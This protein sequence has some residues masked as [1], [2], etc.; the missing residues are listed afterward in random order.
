M[1]SIVA[2]AN[3]II[4][5]DNIHTLTNLNMLSPDGQCYSFDHRG[6][7][8]SR[9]EGVGVLVLKRVSDAIRDN[10]TIRGIIRSTGCNQDGHTPSITLPSSEMQTRLIRDTY[11]KAGLSMEPTR[12]FEAHGTGTSVGDP[13]E[14]KALGA[15]FRHVRTTQDPL[16]VGAIKSN[17]GHMEGSSGVGGVIKAM[18]VL[19]KGL[20]PPNANFEK[21]N[22]KI[23]TD[24]LR[25][26]F[27]MEIMPWPTP[28]L[29]RASV[30]SFGNAGTNSHT[31]L[32]DVYHYLEARGL[33]ARHLTV[34]D[35]PAQVDENPNC[36]TVLPSATMAAPE[37]PTR[38]KLLLLSANDEKGVP[39]QAQA[40]VDHFRKH[41]DP[42]SPR[43]L[44]HLAYTLCFRRSALP[45]TSFAVVDSLDDLQKLDQLISPAIKSIANPSLGFVFAGQGAQWAGMGRELVSFPAFQESLQRSE[46]ILRRLGCPWSLHEAIWQPNEKSRLDD[47][48]RAQPC[49]T[50]LQIALVDLLRSLNVSPAVV[51]GHSSG[52]IAAAYCCGALS[53]DSALKVAY[54]RGEVCRVLTGP[55]AP[56][57]RGAMMSVGLSAQ[58]IGPYLAEAS[59]GFAAPGLTVACINSPRNVTVSGDVEQL[60]ALQTIL[61]ARQIFARKLAV[62]VA[63]HSPHMRRVADLYRHAIRKLLPGAQRL[64]AIAMISSVTGTRIS[65]DELLDPAYWERN[66]TSPVRF[67]DAIDTLVA[68]AAHRVRRKLDLSHRNHFR[69]DMIVE[70]SPH[71]ALQRPVRDILQAS[72]AAAHIRYAAL[73]TKGTDGVASTLA[74]LGAVK[75]LGA[76][77]DL[78]Q[79]NTLHADLDSYMALPDLPSY[80]FDHSQRYWDE[81]RLCA[82]YRLGGH[83]K[84]D[85]LGKPVVDWNP[86][87]PR[88][89]HF[90][91][92]SE[93]PWIEDH[94]VNGVLIYPGAGMLVMALEAAHQLTAGD[95]TVTALELSDVAF[96]K[97]ILISREAEGV[98]LQL[99]LRLAR[100]SQSVLS[101]R[102]EFRL[103]AN[104]HGE[105]TECCHGFVQTR[106]CAVATDRARNRGGSTAELA[107][108]RS[109]AAE[110]DRTCASELDIKQ[111]YT[112]I[113]RSGVE[114]GPAFQRVR[115]AFTDR[116]THRVRGT[117][118]P[119]AWPESEFPQPHL[120][121]PTSLDGVL[122][123][124]FACFGDTQEDAGL[125]TRIPT[126]LRRL[127][128][129]RAGV[130]APEMKEVEEYV[131]R[132]MEDRRG[133]EY[134]AFVLD[135]TKETVLVQFE[136][137]R[138]T[139][140]AASEGKAAEQGQGLHTAFHVEYRPEVELLGAGEMRR[141]CAAGGDGQLQR[142]LDMLAHKNGGLRFVE[143]DPGDAGLTRLVLECL[144]VRDHLGAV[145]W[146]RY[147]SYH[148]CAPSEDVLARRKE[149]LAAFAQ[150]T[151]AV[152]D[153]AK[154]PVKQGL[155]AG[156][157]DVVVA[158]TSWDV[159]HLRSLLSPDGRLILVESEDSEGSETLFEQQDGFYPGFTLQ[160]DERRVHVHQL[161]SSITQGASGRDI[162]IVREGNSSRQT[163]LTTALKE[164]WKQQ[165]IPN[166]TEG[167]LQEATQIPVSADT[168][169]VIL[170]ELDDPITRTLTPDR[171]SPF[172]TLCATASHIIWPTFAGGSA[173][174]KPAFA[175]VH[176]LTRVLRS[177]YPALTITVIDF[178]ADETLIPSQLEKLTRLLFARH[179]NSDPRII[180]SE[181]R[182]QDGILHIPRVTPATHTTHQ[183]AQRSSP[184]TTRLR[185]LSASPPLSL[186]ISSI[187]ILDTLAFIEDTASP[188]TPLA[189]DEIEIAT[190]AIGL[191][192]VD[193]LTALGH[194]PDGP[195]GQ[196]CAGIVTRTGPAVTQVQVGDR[197]ALATEH[198]SFKT[199]F[200]RGRV[201]VRIPDG[202][203]FTTASAIPAQASTAWTAI[204]R[205]AHLQPE[206]SILIHCVAGG[207]GQIAVQLARLLGATV[208]ATVG[209]AE[210][211]QL[212]MDQYQLPESHIFSSRDT[213]FAA[214]IMRATNDRGVDV[215]L[216]CLTGEGL[217][218]S[219]KCVAAYGRFVELARTNILDNAALPM[220]AFRKNVTFSALD[221]VAWR[222]ERAGVACRDLERVMELVGEGLVQPAWP[223]QVRDIGEVN[224]VFREVQLGDAVGKFVFEVRKESKVQATCDTRPSFYFEPN[225][226]FVIAGGLGGIGRATARWLVERGARNLILLSRFGPRTEEG[227]L[228]VQE[229]QNQ[230]VRVE[231]PACDIT[232][233]TRMQEV[234]RG[235]AARMPPIQGAFQM[236]IIARDSLFDT[237]T[238][239]DWQ[240][241]V[242]CKT[243][244]T[245]NLHAVLPRGM[246]FFIILA[247][248]SGLAGIKGQANYNAG[249]TFEDA[250]ARWRV[251]QGEKTTALD[252]GAMVDDGILNEDPNLLS[253]VL[254]YGSLEGITRSEFYGILDYYCD[255][256][257]D[258]G[259]PHEAQVAIGLGVG[260]SGLLGSVDHAKNPLLQPLML[261][262]ERKATASVGAGGDVGA[263]AGAM[264]RQR[265]RERLGAATSMEQAAEV[266]MQATIYQLGKSLVAMQ[267][268]GAIDRDRPLQMY[269]VDSLLAIELRNWIVK[270]FS[271][272][273]AVFETQ[274]ASTLRTLSM[275]V[276]GRTGIK[277]EY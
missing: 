246:D 257:R 132:A 90:L 194:L 108:C 173:W 69:V 131:Y 15:A 229:L 157:F 254:A 27:P 158:S 265:N 197:V 225:A 12:F 110:M 153:P 233:K 74:A 124:G 226:T 264:S 129:D 22:P 228:L 220:Y 232:D 214:G 59:V 165:G 122:H 64:P 58:D 262:A 40:Y 6:N 243:T 252:L 11:A 183:L 115:T 277:H 251:A 266:V 5:P 273:V 210:K 198:G 114:L 149:E 95:D 35:P 32:D 271:A 84:L 204:H 137:L 65:P 80:V 21:V 162:F 147:S 207:T 77:L 260:G 235:L 105:W 106:H 178:D 88:W 249:N 250:F 109:L 135:P 50:A 188:T 248:A 216:N 209:S 36:Q 215:V 10:D 54:H 46:K 9:S 2:G 144:S 112:T 57:P 139:T 159:S 53:A 4:S 142:Y 38:P 79:T 100:D 37:A 70:V 161:A 230:G 130:S 39:R 221:A 45:W 87:E 201:A 275:L 86:L 212:L 160:A 29:R 168:V 174:T 258:L 20:I 56:G 170:L 19:E 49:C 136:D 8:Y 206:E 62:P 179:I 52:E 119:Y 193:T 42:L 195:L 28:G 190:R 177:E 81:S 96:P 127:V 217:L 169:F 98:E 227:R 121:H 44:D 276:A 263:G 274:G 60:G 176:G 23:D 267:D 205:L 208:Y 202:I 3:V 83:P 236:S 133:A 61:D 192:L 128:V 141:Y 47:P 89:R 272:D 111:F 18:L 140:V 41:K 239:P 1:Q 247:S 17:I 99:G 180:D 200:A 14:A 253:K 125:K 175:D 101:Q 199:P 82:N 231:T 259:A 255:P 171:F 48:E 166:V 34:R 67:A 134:S 26:R 85:L 97:P 75:C 68:A 191:N 234:F 7:G 224:E 78:A 256:A 181:Y 151:W 150:L 126:H 218:A 148:L 104:H 102:A 156:G 237:L 213:A 113:T 116:A 92:A 219:W 51:V 167:D 138:L 240:V 91:R 146:P 33:R 203:S 31:V 103:F 155:E 186:H 16:W 13:G 63:Y 182:E 241:A 163:H 117:L 244:G 94:S 185:A 66:M 93:L 223:L 245:W 120:I 172:Q 118:A 71:A 196:E 30:N 25:I 72:R 154:S 222:A 242:D 55:D 145:L 189:A 73:L 270:E 43:Y 268:A 184:R 107:T 164:Y 261:A 187:G 143:L 152:L 24:Y 123:L 269:G 211:K 238:H 76:P